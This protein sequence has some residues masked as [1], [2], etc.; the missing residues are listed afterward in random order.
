MPTQ[1]YSLDA[2]LDELERFHQRAT[3]EAV[4]ALIGRPPHYLTNAPPRN[5]RHSWVVNDAT[6]Q[7]TAYFADQIHPDITSRAR[8]LSSAEELEN[9]LRDPS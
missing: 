6:G 2:I 8:V 5:S 9:W 1:T 3:Y 7:P 4:A